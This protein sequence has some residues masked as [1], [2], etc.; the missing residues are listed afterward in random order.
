MT[1]APLIFACA[2]GVRAES[3]VKKAMELG[4]TNVYNLGSFEKMPTQ[5][6]TPDP[7]PTP[8]PTPTPDPT[9]NPTPGTDDSN[10]NGG[11][12]QGT[13]DDTNTDESKT[14]QSKTEESVATGE[15]GLLWY[16]L[17]AAV[18]ALGAGFVLTGKKCRKDEE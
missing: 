7:T 16:S 9:P 6:K 1:R 14:E 10:G 11:N 2:S 17:S 13:T 12:N 3:A 8:N 5:E 18:T 4:Y 15:R